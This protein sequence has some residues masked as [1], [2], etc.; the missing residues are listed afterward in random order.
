MGA[1]DEGPALH[2]GLGLDADLRPAR[3]GTGRWPRRSRSRRRR[4]PPRAARRPGTPPRRGAAPPP[5][6]TPRR[7]DRP[8]GSG[9]P[10][11]GRSGLPQFAEL[12]AHAVG[13]RGAAHGE[14]G[15]PVERV[16]L[17][18][19]RPRSP[20]G[21][22]VSAWSM[23]CSGRRRRSYWHMPAPRTPWKNRFR[24]A[25][26]STTCSAPGGSSSSHDMSPQVRRP[27]NPSLSAALQGL[28]EQVEHPLAVEGPVGEVGLGVRRLHQRA[29]LR[30][31]GGVDAHRLQR[32][33]ESLDGLLG[34]RDVEDPLARA[35][36]VREVLGRDRE[37]LLLGLVQGADV[38][39]L[40]IFGIHARMVHGNRRACVE[41]VDLPIFP[42]ARAP[43][44]S[45]ALSP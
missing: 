8:G 15:R 41:T 30:A 5:S 13:V 44:A 22:V 34:L 2:E 17:V 33:A 20:T 37:L 26:Y 7:C 21:W 3:P 11:R 35:Q 32:V 4:A 36:A 18:D 38:L 28:V 1:L 23:R 45:G 24:C 6:R 25:S 29:A 12:E 10:S 43:G 42:S 16:R 27:A 14:L 19:A 9:W 40:P 39:P 31:G